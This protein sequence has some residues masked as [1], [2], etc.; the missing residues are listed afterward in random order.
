LPAA[1]AEI[2]AA[3]AGAAHHI[4]K[5]SQSVRFEGDIE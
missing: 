2:T 4:T 3:V 5:V 1:S